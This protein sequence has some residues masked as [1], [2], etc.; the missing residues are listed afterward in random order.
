MVRTSL[1]IKSFRTFKSARSIQVFNLQKKLWANVE[2]AL[3]K[4]HQLST[5]SFKKLGIQ[6]II[7]FVISW[8]KSL[9]QDHFDLEWAYCEP[10]GMW[11][12]CGSMS[13]CII[14]WLCSL[15]GVVL[16]F[17]LGL[18]CELV[19]KPSV[20]FVASGSV[21]AYRRVSVCLYCTRGLV[22]VKHKR[23]TQP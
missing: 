11:F 8:V 19:R 22:I 10:I 7:L 21:E 12:V 15:Q 17:S 14:G 3:D 4:P 16:L 13:A 6:I 2:L 23:P 1:A 5:S 20:L 18:S 9:Q